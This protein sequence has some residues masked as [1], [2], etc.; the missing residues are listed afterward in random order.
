MALSPK[1]LD[2]E[3]LLI[4]KAYV[5]MEYSRE[6]EIF[7]DV[8]KASTTYVHHNDFLAYDLKI[9]NNFDILLCRRSRFRFT[10]SSPTDHYSSVIKIKFFFL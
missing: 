7:W 3:F 5:L 6:L 2:I 4:L 9:I 1:F 10:T 8:C